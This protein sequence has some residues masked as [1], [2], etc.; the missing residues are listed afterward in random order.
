MPE[1]RL[2]RHGETS[3][4]E[5]DLGLSD[6][7]R[8]QARA[9]AAALAGEAHGALTLL[10]APSV[11]ARVTAEV[12]A[13]ELTAA[14]VAVDGAARRARL[15]QLHGGGRR[16]R[17]RAGRGV[18]RVR[19][20][21]GDAAR[22]AAG[23]A[24]RHRPLPPRARVRRRSDRAVADHAAAGLRAAGGVG[25]ALLARHPRGGGRRAHRRRRPLGADA[26]AR[27]A[28]VRPRPRRAGQPRGGGHPPR[29]R[30]R[31]RRLPRRSARRSRCPSSTEPRW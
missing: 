15:R 21:G 3:G 28:R 25:P 26:R 29:G 14:G 16:R 23:L 8:D 31:T 27:R 2:L 13:E 5:G 9:A 1:I 12:L 30:A 22:R 10:Y 7:G 4:Y 6:R 17:A 19:G 11:R 18:R 24:G 20:C